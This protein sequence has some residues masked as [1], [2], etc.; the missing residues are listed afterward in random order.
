MLSW[1]ILRQ[2]RDSWISDKSHKKW[3]RLYLWVIER[4]PRDQLLVWHIYCLHE[5]ALVH[6]ILNQGP[7]YSYS[8][9]SRTVAFSKDGH[10]S[11][12]HY[13]FLIPVSKHPLF[14]EVCWFSDCRFLQA[15]N[16]AKFDCP[17]RF[18]GEKA[19]KLHDNILLHV[20]LLSDSILLH[21]HRIH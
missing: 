16:R 19:C 2:K 18:C 15:E 12:Q 7:V 17:K 5:P 14:P 11:T 1:R 3:Q 9:E 20:L 10:Y 6:R 8:G 21:L 13:E 4:I